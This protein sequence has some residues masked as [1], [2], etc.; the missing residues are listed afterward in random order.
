[1]IN[2]II[3][4][5]SKEISYQTGQ[6]LTPPEFVSLITTMRCNFRCE[7]CSIWQKTTHSELDKDSWNNI[8]QK[9]IRALQP[10]AFIEINGGEPLL[11]G[12][13][14]IYMIREL[15]KYFQK[16]ALNSNGLLINERILDQLKEAGVGLIKISFYSLEKSTHNYLRG[17][18]LAYDNAKKAIEL[19]NAKQIPLE[20][21][22]LVTTQNIDNAPALIQYLQTLPNTTIILQP[23]DEKIESP[24][25]KEQKNNLISNLW[26]TNG[27]VN[28]FFD[29]VVKNP[30][31]IKNSLANIEAIRQYYLEPT[32]ILKYRCFTGQRNLVVYPNGD[33]SLCF[34]GGIIGNLKKQD[35]IKIVENAATERKKIKYCKK[36]CRIIGCNFSRGLKEFTRDTLKN[37]VR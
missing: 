18:N 5:I 36:Y 31:N 29:W 34:K 22:L 20:I 35:L 4:K 13:R 32:S 19:I 25:S 11:N 7:S 3:N 17:H 1:M 21:G 2:K 28:K 24:E 23:L 15:K 14:V 9:L 10:T 6:Y 16:V 26:P 12:P 37:L 27:Q 8:I 30:Q 33:V